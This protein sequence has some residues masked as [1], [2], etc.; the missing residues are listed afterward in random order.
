MNFRRLTSYRYVV[1][2][3]DRID[4]TVCHYLAQIPLL[5][6]GNYIIREGWIDTRIR[7]AWKRVGRRKGG[8]S[9]SLSRNEND[10]ATQWGSN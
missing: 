10:R 7:A 4:D 9:K 5:N 3:Y 1:H 2:V 6:F 8:K